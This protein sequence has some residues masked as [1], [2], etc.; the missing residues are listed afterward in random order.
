MK[1]ILSVAALVLLAWS[2]LFWQPVADAARVNRPKNSNRGARLL[3][4]FYQPQH[5]AASKK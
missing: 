4:F 5:T 2:P 1:T 3:E